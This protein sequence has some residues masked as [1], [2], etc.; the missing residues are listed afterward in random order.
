MLNNIIAARVS[1]ETA[2]SMKEQANELGID[3]SKYINYLH[4][5]H[6]AGYQLYVIHVHMVSATSK[7]ERH[8]LQEKELVMYE[9]SFNW[10][11]YFAEDQHPG[12]RVTWMTCLDRIGTE[13]LG[14]VHVSDRNGKRYVTIVKDTEN[15]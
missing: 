5:Q 3:V 9:S 4:A 10:A 2:Q 8:Y 11:K 13:G 15:E 12:Y 14:R 7:P 6:V 1:H